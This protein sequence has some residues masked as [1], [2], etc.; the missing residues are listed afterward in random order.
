MSIA[1]QDGDDPSNEAGPPPEKPPPP[2]PNFKPQDLPLSQSKRST[3]D[4][5]VHTFKKKGEFDTM[6]K[7]VYAQFDSSVS[8]PPPIA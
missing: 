4:G 1:D 6:R 5:L 3:I 8:P 2:R 7:Q